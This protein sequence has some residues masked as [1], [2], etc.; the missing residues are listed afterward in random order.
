MP[1]KQSYGGYVIFVHDLIVSNRRKN[2]MQKDDFIWYID[3]QESLVK[4]FNGQYLVISGKKVVFHSSNEGEAYRNG[5]E[6]YGLG[7]FILLRC[8]P[9]KE[10]YTMTFHTQRVRFNR[11]G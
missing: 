1:L 10:D 4:E 7:N 11:V 2:V 9:G 8:S 3:N 5:V 6:G